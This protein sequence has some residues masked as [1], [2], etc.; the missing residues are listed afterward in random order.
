M[1]YKIILLFF[2]IPNNFCL[3]HFFYSVFDR[4]LT[5]PVRNKIPSFQ[6]IVYTL[7]WKHKKTLS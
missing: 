4:R 3:S 6:V 2:D 1:P 7:R 5:C